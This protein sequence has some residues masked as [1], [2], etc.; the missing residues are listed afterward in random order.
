MNMESLQSLLGAMAA[1]AG[2]PEDL[3][4]AE[5]EMKLAL[6]EACQEAGTWLG[7]CNAV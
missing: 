5:A 3:S 7:S 4:E 2:N 1:S 6:E